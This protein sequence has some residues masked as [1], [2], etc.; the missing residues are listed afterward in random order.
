MSGG[1]KTLL[2]NTLSASDSHE[3]S[4]IKP[5]PMYFNESRM[6][7]H[8]QGCSTKLGS[9]KVSAVKF[10]KILITPLDHDVVEEI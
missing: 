9:R 5:V 6:G 10:K 7:E 2:I 4:I 3:D 8:S 1:D